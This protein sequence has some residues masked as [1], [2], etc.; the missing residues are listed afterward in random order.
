MAY[1]DQFPDALVSVLA[2]EWNGHRELCLLDSAY[3]N[4]QFRSFLI[5][6]CQHKTFSIEVP[7]CVDSSVHAWIFAKLIRPK[8]LLT[9]CNGSFWAESPLSKSTLDEKEHL[10]SEVTG[11]KMCSGYRAAGTDPFDDEHSFIFKLIRFMNMCPKLS[12]L[13]T[14]FVHSFSYIDLFR[15]MDQTILKQ[16]NS[17][18][19]CGVYKTVGIDMEAL[20]YL[21][22]AC[23]KLVT[24]EMNISGW[25]ECGIFKLLARHS[26]SLTTLSLSECHLT[27]A[28][29]EKL[30]EF[31]SPRV[32][33]LRLCALSHGG[34]TERFAYD[35][36]TSCKVLE[37]L[38]IY[39]KVRSGHRGWLNSI[40]MINMGTRKSTLFLSKL[41]R[42]EDSYRH[43]ILAACPN[44]SSIMLSH[45]R[46][47]DGT[48][49]VL[50]AVL[51][52]NLTTLRVLSVT[53]CVFGSK[54]HDVL[55]QI[56][57]KCTS[58]TVVRVTLCDI[59][60]L[61]QNIVSLLCN[62]PQ[63]ITKLLIGGD[64][65]LDLAGLLA[66]V[67]TNPHLEVLWFRTC[68]IYI[69]TE[70]DF[71]YE[72]TK[73]KVEECGGE[74]LRVVDNLFPEFDDEFFDSE[75]FGYSDIM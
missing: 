29:L 13:A 62:L 47:Q 30:V 21:S 19:L 54:S 64:H 5:R 33:N 43:Q 70:V 18:S 32:K 4:K 2:S 17:F 41:C 28:F 52:H 56:F 48:A 7:R 25:D 74:K 23:E 44:T 36:L 72:A 40:K 68:T 11:I 16:M 15:L 9:F 42:T 60:Q 45:L 35:L 57:A 49:L 69:D 65:S 53:R 14:N 34:L 12:Q 20:N 71:D 59:T 37:N 26:G 46:A 66:I 61:G 67:K 24:V 31:L 58:L 63:N 50:E 22:M 39:Q 1:L 51:L 73:V 38:H 10:F 55:R 6:L 3:C 27:P 75:C 8:G